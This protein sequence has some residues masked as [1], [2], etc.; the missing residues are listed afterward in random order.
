GVGV[1]LTEE[2]V[3]ECRKEFP[4]LEFAAGTPESFKAGEPFDYVLFGHIS[5][6]VDVLQA[7]RNIRQYAMPETRLVIYTYG[8][9]W[10][11]LV[12]LAEKLSWKIPLL[13]QNWFSEIDTEHLLLLGGYELL[14]CYRTI[15]APK[16]IP[17]VSFLLNRYLAPLPVLNRL[18]LVKV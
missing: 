8:H 13:E 7:L 6:T 15:L 14:R 17:L 16:H 9:W 18:C 10:R 4:Q 1:E 3:G 11:P 2:L 5:D 12:I